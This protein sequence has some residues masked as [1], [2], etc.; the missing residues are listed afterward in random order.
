MEEE[1]ARGGRGGEG[2]SGRSGGRKEK[3]M[4]ALATLYLLPPKISLK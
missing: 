4:M 3:Q 2:R 1:E